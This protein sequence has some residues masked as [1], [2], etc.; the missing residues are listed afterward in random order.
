MTRFSA[1]SRHREWPWAPRNSLVVSFPSV[2]NDA[3]GCFE[4]NRPAI[5]VP[6]A[7]ASVERLLAPNNDTIRYTLVFRDPYYAHGVVNASAALERWGFHR[8]EVKNHWREPKRYRGI[9]TTWLHARSGTLIE[10][11]FHTVQT[12]LATTLTHGM[13]ERMRL[14]QTPADVRTDLNDRIASAYAR[15][16]HPAGVEAL[17]R[18]TVP[19]PSPPKPVEPPPNHAPVVAAA[20]ASAAGGAVAVDRTAHET[21]PPPVAVRGA[22]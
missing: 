9:N 17:T 18:E 13:Y 10:V 12:N 20:G 8:V 5:A 4:S 14:P 7:G 1:Y 19:P 22:R 2:C 3:I 11:Q 6:F 21:A 15:V 16:P